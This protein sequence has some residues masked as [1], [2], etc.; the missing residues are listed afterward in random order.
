MWLEAAMQCE[1]VA[2]VWPNHSRCTW[3]PALPCSG[4]CGDTSDFYWPWLT[5]LFTWWTCGGRKGVCIDGIS[6]SFRLCHGKRFVRAIALALEICFSWLEDYEIGC[7]W[8][9][10]SNCMILHLNILRCLLLLILSMS[11]VFCLNTHIWQSMTLLLRVCIDV[12]FPL[13]HAGTGPGTRSPRWQNTHQNG[14]G[15]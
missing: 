5:G 15:E 11:I 14:W 6:I 4:W 10:S 12:K 13:E 2:A 9:L 8:V 1:E 3:D 7:F